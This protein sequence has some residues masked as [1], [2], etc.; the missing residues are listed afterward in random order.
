MNLQTFRKRLENDRSAETFFSLGREIAIE[1]A[2]HGTEDDTTVEAVIRLSDAIDSFPDEISDGLYEMRSALLRHVG[3]FPY[4]DPNHLTFRDQ[5]VYEAYRS[6]ADKSIIYHREQLEIIERLESGR[7]VILSAP[8]SFGKSLIIDM[9]CNSGARRKIVI[10]VPTIALIDETKRR[11]FARFGNS[12][13]IIW[14][15]QQQSDS[16]RKTIY[17]LTQERALSRNDLIHVDLLVVDEFYKIDASQQD[18][19]TIS[20]GLAVRRLVQHSRQF[21]MLGPMISTLLWRAPKI[22]YDFFQTDFRTVAVD[23]ERISSDRTDES[24]ASFVASH[25]LRPALVFCSSPERARDIC[26]EIIKKI[27]AMRENA[28]TRG[29]ASWVRQSFHQDWFASAAIERGIGIHTGRIPRA[30]AQLQIDLFDKG[31]LDILVCTSSI[32]EGVNT[33]AKSV[34]IV[35]SQ[36]DRNPINYFTHENIKGRSGRMFRHF[37][38]KVYLFHDPPPRDQTEIDLEYV[39]G[40]MLPDAFVAGLDVTDNP[41]LIARQQSLS[42]NIGLSPHVIREFSSLTI[43]VL[44]SLAKGVNERIEAQRFG[45]CWDGM[46]AWPRLRST[47]ELIWEHAKPRINGAP[48]AKSTLRLLTIA[49]VKKNVGLFVQEVA[50][51]ER[52]G[53]DE[54]VDVALNF[55]KVMEYGLPLR[56]AALDA[57]IK[58]LWRDPRAQ[59]VN[60][61]AY[62]AS[63]KSWFSVTSASTYEEIGLPTQIVEKYNIDLRDKTP[64]EIIYEISKL[65]NDEGNE[66]TTH[67]EKLFISRIL[68]IT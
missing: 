16:D 35:D 11:L 32:I 18:A 45:I 8:T 15:E 62:I 55:L 1:I 60:Y 66:P 41:P 51:N 48:T 63:M 10:I 22:K 9:L 5:L 46:P 52:K 43:P 67:A 64:R 34:S 26:V 58:D 53:V 29:L 61:S 17:V 12:I 44:A 36:I 42:S 23:I 13:Q 2:I 65:L 38:G 54:G 37:V 14:N 47:M 33:V 7:N 31:I 68:P 39:D 59:S 25:A 49:S 3:L 30:F 50:N 19:R 27:P 21:F 56:L 6:D 4:A 24:I 40:D 28:D 20:L 57:I